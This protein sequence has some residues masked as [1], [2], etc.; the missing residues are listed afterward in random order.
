VSPW[1]DLE[2]LHSLLSYSGP[3]KETHTCNQLICSMDLCEERLYMIDIWFLQ[4]SLMQ[5][6]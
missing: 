4:S 1:T 2:E 5:N 3:W 6:I